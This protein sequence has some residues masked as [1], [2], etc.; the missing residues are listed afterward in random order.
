VADRA[1]FVFR[2][3]RS[4]SGMRHVRPTI[5]PTRPENSEHPRRSAPPPP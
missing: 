5:L 4:A 1:E 3:G 2:D